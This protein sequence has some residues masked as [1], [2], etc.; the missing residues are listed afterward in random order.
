MP[1]APVPPPQVMLLSVWLDANAVWHARVVLPDAQTHEF[2][3]PFDLVQ[4]LAQAQRAPPR[5]GA[6]GLR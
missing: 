2:T 4:F 5:A 3:N 6:T 1:P